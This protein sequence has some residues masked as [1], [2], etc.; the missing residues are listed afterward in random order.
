MDKINPSISAFFPFKIADRS[1][2][3]G[4]SNVSNGAKSAFPP[5]KNVAKVDRQVSTNSENDLRSSISYSPFSMPL[6]MTCEASLSGRG[7][8]CR[9]EMY[10]SLEK[11]DTKLIP[12]SALSSSAT[13]SKSRVKA[14]ELS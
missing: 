4:N 14:L 10:E 7:K 13:N 12:A 11:R 2:L 1:K 5:F 6:R 9:S 8:R 3:Y